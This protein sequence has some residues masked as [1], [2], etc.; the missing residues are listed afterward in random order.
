MDA[1]VVGA[2]PPYSG[3]ICGKLV[4][5]MVGSCEVKKAYEAKY[6]GRTAVISENFR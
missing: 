2:V 5:A 4:A 1:Y 6:L 3:L